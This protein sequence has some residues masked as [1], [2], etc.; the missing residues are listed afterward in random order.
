MSITY[1]ESD[2]PLKINAK[3]VFS[4]VKAIQRAGLEE[5]FLTM[6]NELDAGVMVEA[7]YVNMVKTF[8]F[9]NDIQSQSDE[10]RRIIDSDRC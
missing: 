4:A 2:E 9:E 8:V 7:A 1:Y 5:R 6:C 10:A 3:T